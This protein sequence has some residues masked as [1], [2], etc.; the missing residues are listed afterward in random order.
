M[1]TAASLTARYTA[2]AAWMVTRH[3]GL[4]ADTIGARSRE[5]MVITPRDHIQSRVR[6]GHLPNQLKESGMFEHLSDSDLESERITAESVLEALSLEVRDIRFVL[7][8][9]G[10]LGGNPNTALNSLDPSV[11]KLAG[12]CFVMMC[13]RR[14]ASDHLDM[15]LACISR[16]R[17]EA[18]FKRAAEARSIKRKR[19]AK[20]SAQVVPVGGDVDKERVRIFYPKRWR[21]W[22]DV[23]SND[24]PSD[25]PIIEVAEVPKA[26]SRVL[27]DEIDRRASAMW[28]WTPWMRR[29]RTSRRYEGC[30]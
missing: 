20:T 1:G 22:S 13:K 29:Q 24:V 10:V 18:E 11:V 27:S 2:D 16:R 9:K 30:F 15:V 25:L 3:A 23:V 12:N 26:S 19:K 8:L 7:H 5:G 14:A 4:E 17:R 28:R 6:T 21:E